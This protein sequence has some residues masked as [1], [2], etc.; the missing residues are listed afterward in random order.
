[1]KNYLN[2]YL[3]ILLMLL[4]GCS[5]NDNTPQNNQTQNSLIKTINIYDTTGIWLSTISYEYDAQKRLNKF[6]ANTRESLNDTYSLEYNPAFVVLKRTISS[7]NQF[8]DKITYRLNTNGLADSSIHVIIV[9]ASDSNI[10]SNNSFQYNL[11]GY[12]ISRVSYINGC[13]P[14][15]TAYFYSNSNVDHVT[16]TSSNPSSNNEQFYYDLL[17]INTLA[18]SN[19]GLHFLGKSSQNPLIRAKYESL[20]M[21]IAK[22]SYEYDN[23]G[24]II[25]LS[26]RGVS[27]MPGYDFYSVPILQS[28]EELYYTYY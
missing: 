16:F 8:C 14:M 19:V 10:L 6:Y 20:N 1:M 2:N 13:D 3:I 24:R 23:S 11:D 27:L 7:S 12:I 21:D 15:T 5:K 17:H 26:M 28:N 18:Y 9:S 22:Y 25:H 4:S